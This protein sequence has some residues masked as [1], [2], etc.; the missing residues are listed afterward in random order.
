MAVPSFSFDE[1]FSDARIDHGAQI[2][3][4]E[5]QALSDGVALG[6]N[7]QL[8]SGATSD[9]EQSARQKASHTPASSPRRFGRL[10]DEGEGL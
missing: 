2:L 5:R 1:D 3:M 7:L 10:R 9:E 8:L 4:H 6:A